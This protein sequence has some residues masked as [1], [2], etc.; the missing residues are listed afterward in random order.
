[1]IISIVVIILLCFGTIAKCQTGRRTIK[2]LV[3]TYT[4][5]AETDGIFVYEFDNKTGDVRF[6]S[7]VSG[8]ENPSYLD[9]SLDG[10]FLYAV[11]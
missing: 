1:M 7:K 5:S 4:S 6:V 11:N 2:L 10:R 8:E 9:V 3:D